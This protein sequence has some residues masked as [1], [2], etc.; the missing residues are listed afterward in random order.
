[1]SETEAAAAIDLQWQ[2][3]CRLHEFIE[4][5]IRQDLPVMIE[6]PWTFH[7]YRMMLESTQYGY[8]LTPPQASV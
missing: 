6:P 8:N 1:M 7:Y 3:I 2:N 5:Q 4:H